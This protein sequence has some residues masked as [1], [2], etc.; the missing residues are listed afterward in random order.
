M[1]TERTS[2]IILKYIWA[3]YIPSFFESVE[4]DKII[5]KLKDNLKL[6]LDPSPTTPGNIDSYKSVVIRQ[7]YIKFSMQA[8]SSL[9]QGKT[10]KAKNI[11]FEKMEGESIAE[12]V[13]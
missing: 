11:F 2:L 8:F 3:D 6:T 4:R 1:N 7:Q 9:F 13:V 10:W 5:A 12:I